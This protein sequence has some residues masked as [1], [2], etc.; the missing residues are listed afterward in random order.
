M[1]R[2]FKKTDDKNQDVPI[3]EELSDENKMNLDKYKHA[4]SIA[5]I[6]LI[7]AKCMLTPGT[8]VVD[9]C[10]QT[11]AYIHDN[12]KKIYVD[13][14]FDKGIAFPTCVSIN[15][16][17]GY[18][19]PID[20]DET[21]ISNGDL[22]NVELGVHIDGFPT[23]VCDTFLV[24][25]K[26]HMTEK[27]KRVMDCLTD[28]KKNIKSMVKPG[29]RCNAVCDY[30]A[31]TSKKHECRLIDWDERIQMCPGIYSYQV[32]QDIIH[33][34]NEKDGDYER[35]NRIFTGKNRHEY[36][37]E[38]S[39]FVHNHVYMVDIVVSSGD[40]IVRINDL[41]ET[42]VFR[43]DFDYRQELKLKASKLTLTAFKNKGVFPSTIRDIDSPV[44]RLGLK[45][46]LTAGV[47]D[48]YPV[49]YEKKGEFLARYKY[50][51]I[52][53]NGNGKKKNRNICFN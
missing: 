34:R 41:S 11:D 24:G 26:E 8:K 28:V 25:K 48:Q 47:L 39:E 16:V 23:I 10:K 36:D 17:I 44:I 51:V 43:H 20:G 2:S 9:I 22:V 42:T 12:L 40:G 21:T 32:S 13:K 1:F 30:M 35:H 5:E 7:Y 33:G 38:N 29:K 46:C 27:Q 15:N 4:G 6:A 53:R 14:S 18:F 52:L 31:N 49:M 19:S 3:H 45:E 37:T 50:T